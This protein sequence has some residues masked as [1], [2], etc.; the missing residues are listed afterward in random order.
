MATTKKVVKKTAKKSAKKAVKKVTKK[1]PKKTIKKSLK[2]KAIEDAKKW[3]G[4][5]DSISKMGRPTDYVEGLA[6]VWLNKVR[7]G[8]GLIEACHGMGFAYSTFHDEWAMKYDDFSE[9][10]KIAKEISLARI[11]ESGDEGRVHHGW[12]IAR[13]KCE[14]DYIEHKDKR[15]LDLK[16]K[17]LDAKI[18]GDIDNDQDINVSFELAPKPLDR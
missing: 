6:D 9:A 15:T 11:L 2:D 12:N 3:V 13:L 14:H 18:N 8:E 17:E 7:K 1:T 4:N 16:E 5:V 10:F